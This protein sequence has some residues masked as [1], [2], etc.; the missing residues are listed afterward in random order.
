MPRINRERLIDLFEEM[1]N[2]YSPTGKESEITEFLSGY[3]Y[4]HD[5]P[6][7]LREVSDGRRNIEVVM[8][9]KPVELAFIGHIDT[10]PAFDIENYE[11]DRQDDEIYGLGTADMKGGCAAM[12]EAFVS[13]VEAGHDL[14]GV[15]LFLVVG[16]EENGDG[17]EALLDARSF[18]WA[19]V[20]E[21]T[22]LVPCLGHYGYLE[23]LV[24]A[25]GTRR[26]A[27]QAGRKYNAIFNTL[28]LLLDL[29]KFI[30]K[31]HPQTVINIR[32]LHSSE[33]G[34]AVPASCEAW[35]DFH[36]KPDQ[37]IDG[38]QEK[39]SQLTNE[40]FS[41]SAVNNYEIEFPTVAPGY[42]LEDGSDFCK[43]LKKAYKS[44]KMDYEQGT[45]TSHSDANMMRQADCN[46][47]I[48]GPGSLARA[49]TR[50]EAVSLQQVISAAKIYQQILLG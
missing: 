5:L 42:V 50:D 24:N 29:A 3:L 46:P 48:L 40:Y 25:Y 6:V 41:G 7:T 21:P 20:A 17:T 19:I 4:E 36:I 16:E 2:I 10:V 14:D 49:H 34:F 28:E 30:E 43:R 45:F 8:G 12:I 1:V 38:F 27:S 44:L 35:V 23:M 37:D 22:N 13:L 39:L 18:P 32:S 26:H 47:V 9:K 33:S 31:K 15:G 11:F